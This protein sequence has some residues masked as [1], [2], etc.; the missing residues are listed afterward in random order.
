MAGVGCVSSN[1]FISQEQNIDGRSERSTG[2]E[3]PVQEEEMQVLEQ[4]KGDEVVEELQV[5]EGDEEEV[6]P[7]LFVKNAALHLLLYIWRT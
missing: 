1:T 4:G 6:L 5:E 7:L 2:T 3:A